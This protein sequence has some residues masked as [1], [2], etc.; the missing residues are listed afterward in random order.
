VNKDQPDIN[1]TSLLAGIIGQVGCITI[2][3]VGL[4]LAAGLLLDRFLGT[5]PIFTI[6]LMVGS[7]PV[8]LYIIV[9]VSLLAAARVQQ[10]REPT[11]KPMEDKAGE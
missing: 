4:A 11:T 6:L 3:I 7:V 8:T 9:R 5:D 10:T 2:L 1:Q